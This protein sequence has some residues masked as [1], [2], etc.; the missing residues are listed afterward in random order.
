MNDQSQIEAK[1]IHLTPPQRFQVAHQLLK[2]HPEDTNP[3]SPTPECEEYKVITTNPSKI[4]AVRILNGSWL[5]VTLFLKRCTR[6]D[7]NLLVVYVALVLLLLQVFMVISRAEASAV[8]TRYNLIPLMAAGRPSPFPLMEKDQKIKGFPK[9]PWAQGSARLLSARAE[10]CFHLVPGEGECRGLQPKALSAHRPASDSKPFGHCRK[11]R[12]IYESGCIAV[13]SISE[14]GK[15][16]ER[17][18]MIAASGESVIPVYERRNYPTVIIAHIKGETSKPLISNP[19]NLIAHRQ[20]TRIAQT[21]PNHFIS[22]ATLPVQ[23]IDRSSVTL[24][25]NPPWQLRLAETCP[26]T[27]I[28]AAGAAAAFW[29][30]SAAGKGL[31]HAPAMRGSI[32]SQ[33]VEIL[34]AVST[35]VFNLNRLAPC[36]Y[37]HTNYSL[38]VN[39]QRSAYP[40]LS[41]SGVPQMI[42]ST[43]S[44][45]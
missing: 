8:G 24:P 42:T 37:E 9:V 1:I 32:K 23:A 15:A 45:T 3:V 43:G 12:R 29:S 28:K 4:W 25:K 16:Y 41:R 44:L 40:P 20:H 36:G 17:A 11:A 31:G 18:D 38:E 22:N 21:Y 30:F 26:G 35:L 6:I 33:R 27:H 2:D 13:T 34:I 10:G 7:K 5:L 39:R 19:W 14:A